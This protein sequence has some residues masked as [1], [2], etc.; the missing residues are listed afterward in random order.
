[1]ATISILANPAVSYA[2][3]EHQG[4][5]FW[6][7]CKPLNYWETWSLTTESKFSAICCWAASILHP[8]RSPP[9]YM[10]QGQTRMLL[11]PQFR[12]WLYISVASV[13]IMALNERWSLWRMSTFLIGCSINRLLF[14]FLCYSKGVC[15]STRAAIASE[16]ISFLQFPSVTTSLV[17][18][19][20]LGDQVKD[21]GAFCSCVT[22]DLYY[23]CGLSEHC[24]ALEWSEAGLGPDKIKKVRYVKILTWKSWRNLQSCA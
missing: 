2:A 13:I 10:G 6:I 19:S 9:H 24:S 17:M 11:L 1:M 21:S 14:C 3:A 7:N 16:I 4:C 12:A 22:P 23:R 5:L 20:R 8:N 15:I 18:N